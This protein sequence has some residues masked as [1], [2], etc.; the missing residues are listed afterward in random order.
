MRLTVEKKTLEG[1]LDL[2]LGIEDDEPEGYGEDI[3][4]GSSPQIVSEHVERTVVT[5][6]ELYRGKVRSGASASGRTSEDLRRGL[7]E[8]SAHCHPLSLLAFATSL[9]R[10]AQLSG[11]QRFS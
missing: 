6:L 7:R 9:F 10:S 11:S 2:E 5:F 3:V 8:I 4:T 1:F